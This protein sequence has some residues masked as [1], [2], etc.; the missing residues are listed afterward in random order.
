MV[1]LKEKY[2]IYYAVLIGWSGV[3][4]WWKGIHP[5]KWV[6]LM[7]HATLRFGVAS[8]LYPKTTL[9]MQHRLPKRYVRYFMG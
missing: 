7:P 5:N 2:S 3:L 1:V 9:H 8:P 4:A 6:N